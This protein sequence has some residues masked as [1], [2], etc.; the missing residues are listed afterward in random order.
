M[1]QSSPAEEI[2]DTRILPCETMRDPS[3]E[4]YYFIFFSFPFF[5]IKIIICFFKCQAQEQVEGVGVGGAAGILHFRSLN[6]SKLL[7]CC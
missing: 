2:P 1:E 4:F 5:K 6:V 7:L 3:E